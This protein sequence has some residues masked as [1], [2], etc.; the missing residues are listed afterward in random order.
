[1]ILIF[2]VVVMIIIDNYYNDNNI[3]YEYSSHYNNS[4]R[5]FITKV[6]WITITTT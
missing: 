2:V 3:N 6:A 4:N 5:N 1:M